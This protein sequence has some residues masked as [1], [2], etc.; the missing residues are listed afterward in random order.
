MLISASI[1]TLLKISSSA[2]VNRIGFNISFSESFHY[3]YFLAHFVQY[4]LS[5]SSFITRVS[6]K[7]FFLSTPCCSSLMLEIL[8]DVLLKQR[9][10]HN[11]KMPCKVIFHTHWPFRVDGL[12][13]VDGLLWNNPVCM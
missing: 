10:F 4:Y 12:L 2:A 6:L 8:F 13:Y 5:H 9:L 11:L 3:L 7:I 1:F